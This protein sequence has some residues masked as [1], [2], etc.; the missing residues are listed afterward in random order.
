MKSKST[1]TVLIIED[2]PAICDMIQFV[3]GRHDFKTVAVHDTHAAKAWLADQLPDLILLDW[4]LPGTSGIAYASELKSA[5]RTQTIPII[6]LTAKAEEVHK[7]TGLDAGADDYITK[8]F[9][10]RELIARIHAVLRRGGAITPDG[11]IQAGPISLNVTLHQVRVGES[12]VAITPVL[13]KL[14]KFLM[15]H[16]NRVFSRE[17]LLQHVWSDELDVYE[18]TVDVHIRRLRKILTDYHC[19]KMVR[20]VHG[21]GYQFL[22]EPDVETSND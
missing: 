8:P 21:V 4:M 2:E 1:R 14:L 10:P 17:Q 3:L 20:T 18:R 16:P 7:V 9:S 11:A 5:P 13:F 12:Q 19:E 15:T 6:M 22:I